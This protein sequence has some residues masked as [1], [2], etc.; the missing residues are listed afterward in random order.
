[1]A[2]YV[3]KHFNCNKNQLCLDT[4]LNC[5]QS[6]RWKK[7]DQGE[8]LGVMAGMVWR[9]KQ[10]NDQILYQ[11]YGPSNSKHSTRSAP[12]SK[13]NDNADKDEIKQEHLDFKNVDSLVSKD[14]K[15]TGKRRKTP[16]V[17]TSTKTF[18]KFKIE[19]VVKVE[20]E[21]KCDEHEV[22]LLQDYF[23]LDVDLEELYQ[24]WSL[25]DPNFQKVAAA[26]T[27]I[28]ILRQDPTENLLSFVCSS[29]NHISR[30]SS[31]VEKLCLHYGNFI[32]KV[33]NID[34]Y[35]FPE[36]SCLCGDDVEAKLRQ[37]GFGYRAKF[38]ASIARNITQEKPAQWL[39]SLRWKSY[40][41]AKA[42]LMTLLGVGAKVADCVC[43]M[44]LDKPGA[45]PVDT[46]VWQITRKN[47]MAK[48]QT[49]K[50]LTD[51]LYREIGDF[52]RS[53]WGPYAGWAHSVLFTADLRHNKEKNTEELHTSTEHC[54]KPNSRG[55]N[56]SPNHFVKHTKNK[57]VC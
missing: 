45:L 13:L 1:M 33:D 27:G 31:M 22:Q 24:H 4:V 14:T 26:F 34:Y 55:K 28:R 39:E 37:L 29:N 47:Y 42:E 21:V 10:A 48:L 16:L 54:L 3:W 5:G 6:F 19:D 40:S 35:T 52:Y 38:I 15:V 30:I 32:S 36:F 50:S 49:A 56:R 9:L 8:W 17:A 43:L 51:K 44:S 18:K 7:N 41:E 12:V 11:V 53:L 23:Q 25:K 57:K 20:N 2:A 46:H